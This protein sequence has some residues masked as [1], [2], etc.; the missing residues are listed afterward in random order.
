MKRIIIVFIFTILCSVIFAQEKDKKITLV[1]HGGA[2]TITKENMTSELE[3]AYKE[4]LQEALDRGYT[5]LENGGTSL[6]AVVE[7]IKILEDSPLFNAGKGA[8]FT[9]EGKNELDASIMD[10]KTLKAGAVAGVTRLK[11]PITAAQ[12][13][14]DKSEHVMMAGMGAEKFARSMGLEIVEPSY[15]HTQKRLKQLEKIKSTEKESNGNADGEGRGSIKVKYPDSKFGTVGCVA[16]DQYGNLAAGTSTGGMTNKRYGRIGDSP[17]IGAGTYADNNACAVSA[18]G[19]GEY[20][21]RSV[22]AYDIG[23]LMKYKNMSLKA[24]ADEVVMKKLVER[25]GSGGIIAVDKEGNVAMPFNTAGM[26]RG[27]IK[28]K[29]EGKVFIYKE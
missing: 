12:A 1:I 18:T 26:Y 27:Y 11:N 28:Q 22:V 25:G 19:H 3:K 4:K 23:A 17:I 20:F 29:G 14:M 16:L 8:V 2:G 6:E 24:A 5:V 7:T 13:V 15:F 9:N 10:G 21:I